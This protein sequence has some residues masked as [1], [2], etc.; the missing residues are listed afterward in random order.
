[1]VD[2]SGN[3]DLR[4]AIDAIEKRIREEEIKGMDWICGNLDEFPLKKSDLEGIILGK[5]GN[6]VRKSA[7][8]VMRWFLKPLYNVMCD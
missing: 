4:E 6:P 2:I 7:S 1:M 8:A 3:M 5:A